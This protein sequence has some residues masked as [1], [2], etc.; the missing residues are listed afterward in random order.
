MTILHPS[1]LA[2]GLMACD[3]CPADETGVESGVETGDSVRPDTQESTPG[4]T[5]WPETG[6]DSPVDSPD[7]PVDTGDSW[8]GPSWVCGIDGIPSDGAPMGMVSLA[9]SEMIST[10][11]GGHFAAGDQDGDG[12]SDIMFASLSED[13]GG[14]GRLFSGPLMGE[15]DLETDRTAV[16]IGEPNDWVYHPAAGDV[17]GDGLTD[18]IVAGHNI[19]GGTGGAYV[20]FGPISGSVNLWT[21]ADAL[22]LAQSD[23]TGPEEHVIADLDSDGYG[24]L[25]IGT[26]AYTTDETN[27]GAVYVVPG[28][29]SGTSYLSDVETIIH[30][31]SVNAGIG[32]SNSAGGDTNGDGLT[33]LVVGTSSYQGASGAAWVLESPFSGMIAI[34]DADATLLGDS[35]SRA[36][37]AVSSGGDV[38][39]D[40]YGDVLVGAYFYG[41]LRGR[42]YLIPGPVSGTHAL[43]DS[44]GVVGAPGMSAAV[45]YD[46]SLEQDL[47][48]DGR[49][50]IAIGSPG[51]YGAP[52]KGAV[53]IFYE[54]FEGTV[55]AFDEAEA[56]LYSQNDLS[57]DYTGGTVATAGDVNA[58]GFDDL[59]IRGEFEYLV[60]GGER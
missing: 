56:V 58:D 15:I 23:M 1:F 19:G 14:Y 37:D 32:L 49:A 36:G 17:N 18:W 13:H 35:Y 52:N 46:V 57:A 16:V 11:W 21:E 41:D 4:E 60:F 50:D 5:A 29:V 34:Q 59:Y 51:A 38:D 42:A 10:S 39:G 53:F 45:G 30:S 12:C 40:G 44:H 43:D 9:E 28:P 8:T 33:D 3:G 25:I 31:G 7:S 26:R 48:S 54:P 24:E 6:P 55:D 2:L 47:D 20:A 22:L 27:W